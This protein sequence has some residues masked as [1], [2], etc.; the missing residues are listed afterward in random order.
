MKKKARIAREWRGQIWVRA[1]SGVAARGFTENNVVISKRD[2]RRIKALAKRL[3]F[4]E[5]LKAL[6]VKVQDI[7]WGRPG[8]EE[9]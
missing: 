2:M 7:G 3:G 6:D 8:E 5:E 1:D 4:F 9:E